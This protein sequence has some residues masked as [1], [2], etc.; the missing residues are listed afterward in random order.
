MPLA[1]HF[2]AIYS[3][4]G[5]FKIEGFSRDAQDALLNYDYPGNARELRNMVERAAIISRSRQ[6]EAHHLNIAQWDPQTISQRAV[7]GTDAEKSKITSALE[8][9]K[10]NRREAAKILGISYSSL[11]YKL[12]KL[13][14]E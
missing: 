2:L 8:E 9:A 14:M 12:K 13:G 6:I 10:W 3:Q 5:G 7:S 11:R 4:K 1:E